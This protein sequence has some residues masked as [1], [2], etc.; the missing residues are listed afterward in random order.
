MYRK[1]GEVAELLGITPSAIRKYEEKG[2]LKSRRQTGNDYRQYDVHD[3]A[4]L[5][6]AR[7][8]KN[9]GFSITETAGILNDTR[10]EE[11]AEVIEK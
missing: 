8:Y 7:M 4:K 9:M 3:I 5:I 11:Y 10:I 1:I 2:I 6:R